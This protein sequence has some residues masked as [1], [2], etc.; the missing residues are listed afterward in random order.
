MAWHP[1]W[2]VERFK[3]HCISMAPLWVGEGLED[4]A[5]HSCKAGVE[6]L[7]QTFISV[8]DDSNICRAIDGSDLYAFRHAE[9]NG[10][11]DRLTPLYKDAA[12]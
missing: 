6:R 2:V 10:W 3:P 8:I 1:L 7:I 12:R 11:I 4:A 5:K 9:M